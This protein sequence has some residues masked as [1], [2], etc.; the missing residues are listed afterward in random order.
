LLAQNGERIS[1]ALHKIK[2]KL[3]AWEV[4]QPTT[5]E[6]RRCQEVLDSVVDAVNMSAQDHHTS[7][8]ELSNLRATLESEIASR[9]ALELRVKVSI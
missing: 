6:L 9:I 8:A 2:Q 7:L 4:Q 5:S 3:V 1:K